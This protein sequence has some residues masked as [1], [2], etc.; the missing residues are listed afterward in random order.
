M[1]DGIKWWPTIEVIKYDARSTAAL[2]RDLGH[3]PTGPELR[4]LEAAGRIAPDDITVSEGN[5][6]VIN[7]LQRITNMIIGGGGTG[8]TA[9]ITG[10][11][12]FIGVGATGGAGTGNAQTALSANGGSA[13]YKVVDAQPTQSNTNSGAGL[14]TINA[15]CTYGSGQAE[16]AWAEWCI[17]CVASGTVTTN[18]TLA[19][20]GT[21]AIILNRKADSLGTKG[22][23]STWTLAAKI[24]LS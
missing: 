12:G 22:A 4:A 18:A 16:F 14:D 9:A 7:G 17:G 10:T 24:V 1:N 2:T 20:V 21:G 23:G 3:A 19:S 6:L 5:L 15:S 13:L 11:L 8:G